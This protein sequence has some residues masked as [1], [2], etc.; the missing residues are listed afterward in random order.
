MKKLLLIPL[1][2]LSII[3]YSIEI[4][5]NKGFVSD[6]E[7]LFTSDQNYELTKILSEYETE[8]TIEIAILTIPDYEGDIFDF[9]QETATAWGVGKDSTDNGLLIVISKNRRILRSQTGYGLE[10][11]LPDGWLKGIEDSITQTY[12]KDSLYYQGTLLLINS[13]KD[14]IKKEGGYTTE[15][16]KKLAGEK[17]A[18][19]EFLKII[20]WW[21][22]IALVVGWFILYAISPPVAL[23]ILRLIIIIIT[24]GKGGGKGFGGGSFGGGGSSSSWK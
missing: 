13:C 5:K 7:N 22:W 15:N 3:L 9:A 23:F 1:L 20:P 12:Y 14:R 24:A 16:N 21:V 4:P 18:I 2:F 17:N 8:T 10:G 11:Y 19:I 6:Y